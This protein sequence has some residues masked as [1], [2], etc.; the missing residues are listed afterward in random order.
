LSPEFDHDIA[1]FKET[2]L[3]RAPPKSLD[4]GCKA[5]RR[6]A[7]PV[8]KRR[9]RGPCSSNK[10]KRDD[11]FEAKSSRSSALDRKHDR[12]LNTRQNA[13]RFN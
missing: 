8:R 12:L 4:P 5:L 2:G 11:D 13:F 10:A 7:L 6:K 9:K 3:A 1:S